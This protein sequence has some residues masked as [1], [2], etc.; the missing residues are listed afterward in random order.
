MNL[1]NKILESIYFKTLNLIN[2]NKKLLFYIVL[3][4]IFFLSALYILKLIF[5]SIIF[6]PAITQIYYMLIFTIIYSFGILFISFKN[7]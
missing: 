2:K 1:K 4:D 5:D 7:D 6:I 3:L